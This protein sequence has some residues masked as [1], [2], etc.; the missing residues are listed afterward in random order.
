MTCVMFWR[1]CPP[2]SSVPRATLHVTSVG[3]REGTRTWSLLSSKEQGWVWAPHH[4]GAF[5]GEGHYSG[6]AVQSTLP[7]LV[8]PWHGVLLLGGLWEPWTEGC[9]GEC[10]L[11]GVMLQQDVTFPGYPPTLGSTQPP[12][13]LPVPPGTLGL[14]KAL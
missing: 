9:S 12:P 4:P 2:P 10:P 3:P 7:S 5:L 14:Q 13:A 6:G 1:W 8:G 11:P